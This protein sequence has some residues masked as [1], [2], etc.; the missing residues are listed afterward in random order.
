MDIINLKL[1]LHWG[2][3]GDGYAGW[4]KMVPKISDI[5]CGWPLTVKALSRRLCHAYLA[6]E[7]MPL[8]RGPKM[9]K[10][11]TF[12]NKFNFCYSIFDTFR[13][14]TRRGV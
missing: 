3:I 10:T 12:E 14:T 4:L 13:I 7:I 2:K 11:L 5:I 1:P 6:L 8:K 9:G